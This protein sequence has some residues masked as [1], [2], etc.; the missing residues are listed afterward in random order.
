MKS[1]YPTLKRRT[2]SSPEESQG[3]FSDASWRASLGSCYGHAPPRGDPREVPGHAGGTLS[4]TITVHNYTFHCCRCTNVFCTEYT[5]TIGAGVWACRFFDLWL[6]KQDLCKCC[7]VLVER[8]QSAGAQLREY[9]TSN[10]LIHLRGGNREPVP[11]QN[12]F[13]LTN[14]IGIVRPGIINSS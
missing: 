6:V 14:S 13:L 9:A 12:Q 4:L 8:G 7:V 11:T 3:S 5:A 2:P 1:K 10:L